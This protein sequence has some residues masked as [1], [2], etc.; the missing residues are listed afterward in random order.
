MVKELQQELRKFADT[1]KA[2]VMQKYFKTGSGEYGENDIFIG[3]IAPYIRVVAKKY[4]NL[5]FDDIALL[6]ASQIHE[7]RL[8]ALFILVLQFQ[9]GTEQEKE[10][11]YNFYLGHLSRVNNWDLVDAS[12]DK[13]VGEWL[14]DKEKSIL[15]QLAKS[16]IIWERRIA[17]LATF[18]SIRKDKPEIAF[19]I[20]DILLFD[21]EDLI[22]KAVGWMLREVGKLCSQ[23]IEEQFLKTRYQTMPRTMLRYAIERFPKQLRQKYLLGKI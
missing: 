5:S 7:E 13:I 9:K 12:A 22:Q 19:E 4:K 17:M 8:A 10:E 3:V 11:I 6:L 20:A 14:V 18:E 23:E 15:I 21:S 1:K 16:E 2:R